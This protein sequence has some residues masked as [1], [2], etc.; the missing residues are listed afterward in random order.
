MNCSD[1]PL[2]QV[3]NLKFYYGERFELD[4]TELV[5]PERCT[6]G[7]IGPNG[8]GKST[9]LKLLAFLEHPHQGSISFSGRKVTVDANPFRRDVTMLLQEPYLLKRTV[10]ENVAYGLKVRG[11]KQGIRKKV[12]E[13]LEQVGLMPE[14]FAS[15]SWHELSGGEAQRVALASRLILRPRVLILDEPTT[16]VDQ[17]SALLIKEAINICRRESNTTL[18]IA[19]HDHLWL[20]SV[21]DD[22]RKIYQGKIVGFATENL[23]FG[24]WKKGLDSLYEKILP[25]GQVIHAMSPPDGGATAILDSSDIMVSTIQPEKL[26]AQNALS[27]TVTQISMESF[28][29]TMIVE[30]NAGGQS[31]LCRITSNAARELNILPG[32]RVWAVFKASSLRWY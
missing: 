23:I 32:E 17:A 1:K 10:F 28:S 8:G 16:S 7:F 2:Y 11:E 5:I 29:D 19:S 4:I 24:P 9:L 15:R 6:I 20:T 13:S 30:L 26:S 22:I 18:L 3:E 12:H 21:T 31:L 27:G 14:S 25:D